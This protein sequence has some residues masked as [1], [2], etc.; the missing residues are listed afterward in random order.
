MCFPVQYHV[1]FSSCACFVLWIFFKRVI[2][3]R[4]FAGS[5]H[6]IE[7]DRDGVEL[8]GLQTHTPCFAEDRS[9]FIPSW[10]AALHL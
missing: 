8:K 9:G 3:K 5:R 10:S 4:V 7:V 6:R 1:P 2:L